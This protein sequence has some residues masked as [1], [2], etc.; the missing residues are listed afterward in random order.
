VFENPL[1]LLCE[2]KISN[3][4]SLLPILEKV[5]KTGRK[6]LIIAENVEGDALST[7]IVNKLKGFE[8]SS[9]FILLQ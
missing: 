5:V 6:L 1:I 4:H 8:V 7:L 3:I 2:Q 9:S